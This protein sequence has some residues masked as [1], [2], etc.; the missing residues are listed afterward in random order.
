MRNTPF[1]EKY[2]FWHICE[3]VSKCND[4]PNKELAVNKFCSI[5]VGL[6]LGLLLCTCSGGGSDTATISISLG[7]LP[8]PGRAAV[9]ID[10]LVHIIK[11]SGPTGSQTMTVT[12]SGT[13]KATVAVGTWHIRVEAFFEEELYAVGSATA[14][15]KAGRNTD[16]LIQMT[17]VWT[18]SAGD[19]NS[20]GGGSGGSAGSGISPQI[21]VT[22]IPAAV[23][24]QK[25]NTFQF[26]ATVNNS[27]NQSLTWTVSSSL[28]NIDGTG[29]LTVG[30]SEATGAQFTVTATSVADNTK[31]G[32][33]VVTVAATPYAITL[34]QSG[35]FTFTPAG[36][37]YYL[38][39]LTVTITNIGSNGTG[40]LNVG[41]TGSDSSSFIIGLSPPISDIPPGGTHTFTVVQA[42]SLVAGTYNDATVTVDDGG[43]NGISA[44]FGLSFTVL[45]PDGTPVAPWLVTNDADLAAVGTGTPTGWDLDKSYK[46]TSPI[47]LAAP[48]NP[49]GPFTGSYDGGGNT[50]TLT[51]VSY[52]PSGVYA[53]LFSQIVSSGEVKNL[54]L[55]GAVTVTFSDSNYCVAGVVAGEND[56]T[57]RNVSSSVNFTVSNSLSGIYI[58]GIAGRCNGSGPGIITNCYSTNDISGTSTTD[59]G[60]GGILGR[61][62]SAPGS[63][64]YCWGEGTLSPGVGHAGGIVGDNGGTGQTTTN[65]VALHDSVASS[66]TDC[67]IMGIQ[68]NSGLSDNFANASM[69]YGGYGNVGH[70]MCNG[71][72]V[73]IS[74]TEATDGGWWTGAGG[75]KWT[76]FWGGA[77]ADETKPWHWDSANDRPMLWF[78]TSVNR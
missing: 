67:R 31:S 59:L 57:I 22:I 34:N 33:A 72:P 2:A 56:G 48:W 42:S 51:S 49:I 44:S 68:V 21:S 9:S 66:P 20:G 12:G 77:T 60:L 35:I 65:C 16:V 58:G 17:V 45:F 15:V 73:S 71:E 6:A 64:S 18:D 50:I 37:G 7:M 26:N 4:Y 47:T 25:G 32:S 39:P 43:A 23:T 40:S 1:F 62:Q 46:Q 29:F 63:V 61:R 19:A 38:E 69:V 24:V 41:I 27:T 55:K 78:E 70:D 28:S 53:G 14:E 11:L 36:E 76:S 74:T 5:T 10:H 54:A 8:S 3:L 13:A 52:N 30:M 75:P